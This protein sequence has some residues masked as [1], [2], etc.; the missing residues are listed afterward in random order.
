MDH[1]E[2][3]GRGTSAGRKVYK[4][5]VPGVRGAPHQTPGGPDTYGGELGLLHGTPTGAHSSGYN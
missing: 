5:R 2:V 4:N 1:G 3:D